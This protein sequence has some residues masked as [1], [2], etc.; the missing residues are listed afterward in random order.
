LSIKL[1]IIGSGSAVPTLTRGVT[2]Q[3][4][5]FNERHILIDCGEGTQLLLRK[6][7]VRFQRIQ[8]IFISHL[9]GDHYL[10]LVG[11]LASMNLLGR[12][13]KL[14]IFA[15]ADLEKI[16]NFQFD[17]THVKLDFDI[18]FRHLSY[19]EKT[20]ILEDRIMEVYA[21]PLKH[22][23]ECY[24]FLFKEKTK[25]LNIKTELIEKYEI[26]RAEIWAIKNGE[27]IERN[28]KKI[29]NDK[30]T[31]PPTQ[32]KQYAFCT[33][34]KFLNKLPDWIKDVDILYHEA[35]FTEA[36]TDRAKATFH[37]T[38]AQAAKIAKLAKAK[39]LLLGHFS[40]RYHTTDELLTEA[41][42]LFSEVVCVEDGDEFVL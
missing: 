1:K 16:V 38:A 41:K 9:H 37:S 19:K 26:T 2:S 6:H 5:N 31:L 17:L 18:E 42:E 3:Y 33:D 20:L 11:L 24:G 27:G 15:P 35:T 10:G 39:K 4:L 29:S 40:A 32:L 28:G 8:Y 14:I 25:L 12:T 21:F 22:R 13:A 36:Y 7:K 30:L 23:I 34:T